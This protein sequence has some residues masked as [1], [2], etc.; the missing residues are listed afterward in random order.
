MIHIAHFGVVRCKSRARKIVWWPKINEE[1]EIFINGC[2][3]CQRNKPSEPQKASEN[4]WPDA[5]FPFDRVHI[6]LAGPFRGL[7]FLLLVD[8][9]SR[10]PFAFQMSNTNSSEIIVK[11]KEIFSM[12]GPPVCLVSD[13]GPQFISHE[14]E[15]FLLSIGVNHIKSPPYH[16]ASNGLCERFVRTFKMGLTKTSTDKELKGAMTEFLQ[17]YRAC[18][19][20]SLDGETPAYKFIGRQIRAKIDIIKYAPPKENSKNNH[21]GETIKDKKQIKRKHF[22]FDDL[23]WVRDYAGRGNWR[24]GKIIGEKG[25]YIYQVELENDKIINAHT[26]QLRIR[27]SYTLRNKRVFASSF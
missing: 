21:L 27:K 10:Y 26:D 20:P 13:N 25:D 15:T 6:D 17:E 11:L 12:F 14:F 5:L 18:P 23:V 4:T 19:H 24:E 1:I 8:A 3:I 7:N 9:Y 2:S 22:E 16:P